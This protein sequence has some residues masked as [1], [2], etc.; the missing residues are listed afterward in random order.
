[1][2]HNSALTAFCSNQAFTH[3]TGHDPKIFQLTAFG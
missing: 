3:K 1:L 2:P